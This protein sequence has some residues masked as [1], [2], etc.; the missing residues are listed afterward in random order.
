MDLELLSGTTLEKEVAGLSPIADDSDSELVPSAILAPS[1]IQL[2]SNVASCAC[3]CLPPASVGQPR[4]SP[5]GQAVSDCWRSQLQACGLRV[6][7][8]CLRCR[9]LFSPVSAGPSTFD[10]R[11]ERHKVT[12]SRARRTPSA[13]ARLS[14]HHR[15]T[16][17]P[18]R[19]VQSGF[20]GP[21]GSPATPPPKMPIFHDHVPGLGKPASDY[22]DSAPIPIQ[23]PPG[24][25]RWLSRRLSEESIRTELCEGPVP[26]SPRT[27]ATTE[28]SVPHA[29]SDR[30]ELIVRLKRGES[31]T[32]I[33]NRHV[34]CN[35][36]MS[37][38][39]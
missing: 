4:R 23:S 1:G 26:D 33:P 18:P 10:G 24:M 5:P 27:L 19:P 31:P 17:N 21:P 2:G 32:W 30:A 35:H 3:L 8:L 15:E 37:L 7:L 39:L 14:Q 36:A 20:C 6:S 29:V 25:G 28:R 12:E 9:V 16:A 13:F 38:A 34:C 11:L 22:V